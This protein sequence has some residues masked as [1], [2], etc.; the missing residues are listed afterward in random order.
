G[1]IDLQFP[2]HECEI[3][4]AEAAGYRFARHWMHHNHVLLAG[5]KM[6]KSTG[7]LVLLHDLLKAHEPMALRF[8]L[9][10][11]HYRSPMDFTFEGLEA[12]KRG[13]TRLLNAY[14]EVRS[15]IAAATPGTTPGLERALDAL[16]KDFLA[17]IE[18][19]LSTPEAL[20]AFFSFLPELNKLLP[21][22][23]GD[24]LKRTAQVFHSLGEGILGLFPERVVEERVSGPLLDGLIALL[25]ELREEARRSKDYAKRDLIRERLKALGVMVE[26]T[27][28]GPKWR[29]S[30][31]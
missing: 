6:A 7:N 26:D 11:T 20:A 25:L 29:L 28:E 13:Y 18:D 31:E 1:G 5:E 22:A 14:R 10:Q 4:Q 3:A 8:Y 19:D 27:K 23:K 30:L 15:R 9:L 24:T 16:E 21:E 17:A 12:A 2:H